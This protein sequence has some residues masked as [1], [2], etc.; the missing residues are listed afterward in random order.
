MQII[1]FYCLNSANATCHVPICST[2]WTY[3]CIDHISTLF[4][5]EPVIKKP[6]E[7][8]NKY[9]KVVV[10]PI[11]CRLISL[12]CQ[13]CF[14]GTHN[15]TTDEDAYYNCGSLECVYNCLLADTNDSTLGKR[16]YGPSYA[17]VGYNR[18]H[19]G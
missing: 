11:R 14:R 7:C 16:V 10:F 2:L 17:C 18:A 9:S 5:N 8:H 19:C 12:C 13:W 1:F 6:V 4:S 15:L 3:N